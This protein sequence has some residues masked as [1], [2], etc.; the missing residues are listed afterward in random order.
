MTAFS[1]VMLGKLV[2]VAVVCFVVVDFCV[3]AVVVA[4]CPASLSVKTI[5]LFF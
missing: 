2:F 5:I 4:L 1:V 3:C